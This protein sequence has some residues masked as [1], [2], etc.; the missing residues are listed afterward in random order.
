MD[1][2]SLKKKTSLT[3]TLET[4]LP[5]VL[6]TKCWIKYFYSTS[7]HQPVFSYFEEYMPVSFY[8]Y[9]LIIFL[10]MFTF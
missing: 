5:L 4:S 10:T 3:T 6:E 7:V 9:L 1:L 2:T 8:V